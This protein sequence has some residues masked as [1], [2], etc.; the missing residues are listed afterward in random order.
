MLGHGTTIAFSTSFL[1]EL[2]SVNWSGMERAAVPTSDFATTGAKTYEPADTYEGGELVCELKHA[3]D[4]APPIGGAAET[5]TITYPS[6]P[7][8]ED[9]FSGFMIGYEW[10]AADEEVVRATA[11]IKVAGTPTFAA[12]P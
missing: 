3:A 9:S 12:T 1:A 8:K 4:V 6:S 5:V 10:T 7:A 2:L 11:R